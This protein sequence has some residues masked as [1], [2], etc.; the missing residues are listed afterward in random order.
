MMNKLKKF[1]YEYIYINERTSMSTKY[2]D[3]IINCIYNTLK[4]CYFSESYRKNYLEVYTDFEKWLKAYW[5][6]ERQEKYKNKVLFDTNKKEDILSS[7]IYYISGMTDN[8]AIDTYNK[9][10][11]F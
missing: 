8:F 7:I 4:K 10:I 2:F 5:N 3:L 9:I 6:K 11:G 1:N